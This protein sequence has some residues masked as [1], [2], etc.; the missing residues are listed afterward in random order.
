MECGARCSQ[1]TASF[2][3]VLS[4]TLECGAPCCCPLSSTAPAAS[5]WPALTPG[6][7]ANARLSLQSWRLWAIRRAHSAA[8]QFAACVGLH[9]QTS[10]QLVQFVMRGILACLP[11]PPCARR[12]MLLAMLLGP[13]TAASALGIPVMTIGGLHHR[14]PLTGQPPFRLGVQMAIPSAPASG[15]LIPV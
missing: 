4:T 15:L 7:A 3:V 8:P 2:L 11:C 10:G 14:L 13:N 9:R 1:P 12:N 5:S 6:G